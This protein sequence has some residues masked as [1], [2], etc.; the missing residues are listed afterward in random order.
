MCRFRRGSASST[1]VCSV[2]FLAIGGV[3]VGE[4]AMAEA[5][6]S[7]KGSRPQATYASG[8]LRVSRRNPRYF[9]DPQGRIVYL[10]GMSASVV[11]LS[12]K[13]SEDPPIPFDFAAYLAYL[14]RHNANLVRM[15]TREQ[16][17]D[18]DF[19]PRTVIIQPLPWARTGPG[20]ALDGKPKF[21]LTKF[22]PEYFTRM[23][24]RAVLAG[25]QGIYLSLMLFEGNGHHFAAMRTLGWS[26]HP[27]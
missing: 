17:A 16:V 24:E 15:W 21:D 25:R 11:C 7:P 23:R 8:P 3:L 20:L 13:G 2:A 4:A 9:E 6:D 26:L 18:L 1:C 19:L 12:D 10:T 22:D 5:H 14:Q 27:F